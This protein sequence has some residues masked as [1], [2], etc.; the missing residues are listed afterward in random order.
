[1]AK[2]SKKWLADACYTG[3]WDKDNFADELHAR[4]WGIESLLKGALAVDIYN[5]EGDLVETLEDDDCRVCADKYEE[6][7]ITDL[8][9]LE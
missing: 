8:L 1:M 2:S 3:G 6:S 4:A 5:P 7:D 9:T